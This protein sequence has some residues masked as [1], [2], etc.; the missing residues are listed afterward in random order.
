MFVLALLPLSLGAQ[1]VRDS[2]ITVSATRSTRVFPDRASFY[3]SVEGTA[4]TATDALVRAETKF[5]GVTDAIKALGPRAEMERPV[6][7]S[8]GPTQPPNGYPTVPMPGT[9][10]ARMVARVQVT[11]PEQLANVVSALLG[12]GA[13]ATAM[14]VFETTV[15]DS[16]R[17]ARMADALSVARK[18]AEAIAQSLGGTLGALVD[19]SSSSPGA[20]S[21]FPAAAVFNF[22][23]RF[24]QSV[25]SPEVPITATV[26][27]RYRLVR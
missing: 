6:A 12:G 1:T 11:R 18:D 9:N 20:N 26:T 5:K 19:V 17:R 15:A 21:V 27:L 22:D 2:V 3:V 4:E 24:Q 16:I 13:S 7:Y 25:P 14:L 8:V 23:T 10:T